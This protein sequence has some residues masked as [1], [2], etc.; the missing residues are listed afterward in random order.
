MDSVDDLLDY[1][2]SDNSF[3]EIDM[4][5]YFESEESSDYGDY[6]TVVSSLKNVSIDETHG[7]VALSVLNN[8]TNR[9]K[10]KMIAGFLDNEKQ[11][12][13]NVR[14]PQSLNLVST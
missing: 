7:T 9:E 11:N 3:S 6:L 12:F 8:M 10:M 1:L 14:L 5:E 13:T 4:L 2:E